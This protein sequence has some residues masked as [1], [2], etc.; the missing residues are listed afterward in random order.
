MFQDDSE[1]VP[2][3]NAEPVKFSLAPRKEI[4]ILAVQ[5]TTTTV[6][7][8]EVYIKAEPLASPL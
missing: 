4:P 8:E 1:E 3:E 7:D 5:N 6:D 2:L